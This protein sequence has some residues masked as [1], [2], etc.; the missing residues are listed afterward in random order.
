MPISRSELVRDQYNWLYIAPGVRQ[1]EGCTETVVNR[2]ISDSRG[3]WAG[4]P[5]QFGAHA[6]AYS[7]RAAVVGQLHCRLRPMAVLIGRP[8]WRGAL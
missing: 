4:D 6:P 8:S 2:A 1:Y 5:G 7:H 3:Q